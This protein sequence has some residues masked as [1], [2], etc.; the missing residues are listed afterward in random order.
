MAL[1]CTR[2]AF[3]LDDGCPELEVDLTF[4][5]F[6]SCDADTARLKGVA[7]IDLQKSPAFPITIP[8]NDPIPVDIPEIYIECAF[9]RVDTNVSISEDSPPGTSFSLDLVKPYS[10][11]CAVSEMNVK[12]KVPSGLAKVGT[13]LTIGVPTANPFGLD[14]STP[15]VFV[16]VASGTLVYLL[17]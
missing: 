2:E 13:A 12:L 1:S 11:S 8:A 5:D 10:D 9:D 4:P 15:G 3:K 6:E 14:R 7:K 16:P 17:G